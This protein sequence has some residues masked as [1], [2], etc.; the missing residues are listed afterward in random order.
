MKA[1]LLT[2]MLALAACDQ[3]EP[4]PASAPAEDFTNKRLIY[5]NRDTALIAIDDQDRTC[6][7][8]YLLYWG[9]RPVALECVRSKQ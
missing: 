1:I 8:L 2:S 9:W 6:Y 4:L 3:T 5:R 7:L